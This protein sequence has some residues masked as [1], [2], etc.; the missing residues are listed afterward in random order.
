MQVK[1]NE[2]VE[3]KEKSL[4]L[5]PVGDGKNLERTVLQA[6]CLN[7]IREV[8]TAV[9]YDSLEKVFPSGQFRVWGVD[10]QNVTHKRYQLTEIGDE[11]W[12]YREGQFFLRAQIMC[13]FHNGKLASLLWDQPK[14]G[15][16]FNNLY[17][18]D[19]IKDIE[20][21]VSA[22]NEVLR[23]EKIEET[24]NPLRG[25]TVCSGN[26]AKALLNL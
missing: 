3:S 12:F 18:F 20:V 5:Q 21:P 4:I 17:F 24:S 22:I 15:R 6:V 14:D 13:K 16:N 10:D 7:D 9:E 1:Q 26:Q 11:V 8:L 19:E 23:P 25:F 2:K